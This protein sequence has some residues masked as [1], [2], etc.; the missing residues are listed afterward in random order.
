MREF[1]AGCGGLLKAAVKA[2]EVGGGSGSD[3]T[4][5]GSAVIVGYEASSGA[6]SEPLH[7]QRAKA[8]A[9]SGGAVGLYATEG[10]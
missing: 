9:G 6:G 5:S 7:V 8:E 1:S 3:I 10:R 2:E 4:L